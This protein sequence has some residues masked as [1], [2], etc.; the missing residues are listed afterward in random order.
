MFCTHCFAAAGWPHSAS[1]FSALSPGLMI[2]VPHIIGCAHAAPASSRA[3]PT[4]ISRFRIQP[5]RHAI[6]HC[7]ASH[8]SLSIDA[9][10]QPVQVLALGMS[11]RHG[12]IGS[13]PEML[14]DLYVASSV[15]RRRRDDLAKQRA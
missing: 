10:E 7:T 1:T 5:P 6:I 12:M 13:R 2:P 9:H 14:Q 4:T 15:G 8:A 11:E 3:N